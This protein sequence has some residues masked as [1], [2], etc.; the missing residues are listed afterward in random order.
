MTSIVAMTSVDGASP[1]LGVAASILQS[2]PV[3]S[4]FDVPA[5]VWIAFL[6]GIACLLFFDLLVVHRKPHAIVGVAKRC[7]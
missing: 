4:S 5:W 6:T 1:A 2:G 3:Y 7:A